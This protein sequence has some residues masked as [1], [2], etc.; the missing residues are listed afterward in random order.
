MSLN[1]YNTTFVDYF[2]LEKYWVTFSIIF[3]IGLTRDWKLGSKQ[4]M[5]GEEFGRNLI[6]ELLK[7][8]AR[9]NLYCLS[10]K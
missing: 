7:I 9:M 6:Y 8:T 2:L 4:L 10:T 5:V 1:L 3:T